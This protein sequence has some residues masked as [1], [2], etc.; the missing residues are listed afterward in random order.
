MSPQKGTFLKETYIHLPTTI[1]HLYL[2]I[3]IYM[4]DWGRVKVFDTPAVLEVV[5]FHTFCLQ[6]NHLKSSAYELQKRLQHVRLHT[7][8]RRDEGSS[9]S[10]VQSPCQRMIGVYNHLLSKVFR[11]HYHSQKVI[12]WWKN[13]VS[14]VVAGKNMSAFCLKKNVRPL[15]SSSRVGKVFNYQPAVFQHFQAFL[16]STLHKNKNIPGPS[17]GCH[18]DGK[19]CH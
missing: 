18:M 9:L 2:Y 10:L 4:L 15:S 7:F 16:A 14:N 6:S 12:G 19:G 5:S 1:F 11:F 3:Y 8:C 17:N 13:Q